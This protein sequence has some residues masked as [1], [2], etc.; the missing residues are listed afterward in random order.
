MNTTTQAQQGVTTTPDGDTFWDVH[1]VAGALCCSA[2]TA[3]RWSRRSGFPPAYEFGPGI[4]RWRADEV[5]AWRQGRQ[6]PDAMAGPADWTPARNAGAGA[7]RRG[8]RRAA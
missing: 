2:S 5:T 8:A 3:R 7:A 1:A 6:R 4:I